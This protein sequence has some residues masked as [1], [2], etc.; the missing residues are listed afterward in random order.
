MSWSTVLALHGDHRV[1][2]SQKRIGMMYVHYAPHLS[3]TFL[4]PARSRFHFYPPD[5]CGYFICPP[6]YSP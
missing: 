6:S 1:L 3:L 2:T 4:I 5:R